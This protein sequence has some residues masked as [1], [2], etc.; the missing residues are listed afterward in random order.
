L[1][2]VAFAPDG[3]RLATS[4]DR[5][6]RVWDVASG[7]ELHTLRHQ[8]RVED[9]AFAPDGTRLA[10]ANYDGKARVWELTSNA[11]LLARARTRVDRQL[12][13]NELRMAG[14]PS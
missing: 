2:V 14:L 13:K 6:A 7:A 4:D 3:T 12:T 1:W 11:L 5:T 10:T 8:D 9:V